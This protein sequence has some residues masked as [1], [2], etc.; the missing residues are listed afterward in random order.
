MEV[1]F[2]VENVLLMLMEQSG[3]VELFTLETEAGLLNIMNVHV[4]VLECQQT[5]VLNVEHLDQLKDR[6]T[7]QIF[8]LQ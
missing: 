6:L 5:D 7:I 8:S 1:F 2:V 4:V 3:W